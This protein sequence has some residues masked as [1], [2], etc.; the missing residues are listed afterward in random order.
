MD[1]VY[2]SNLPIGMNCKVF[3]AKALE[4]TQKV[5][6]SKNNSNGFM[7]LFYKN[8]F[9]KKKKLILKNIKNIKFAL[10]LII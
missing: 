6:I 7:Q 3:S 4:L 8:P 10:H 1:F 5:K 2:T 9:L